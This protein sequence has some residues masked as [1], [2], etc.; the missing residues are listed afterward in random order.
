MFYFI[1]IGKVKSQNMYD[2]SIL[3]CQISKLNLHLKYT[4]IIILLK[5]N[6]PNPNS[7]SSQPTDNILKL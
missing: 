7:S 3:L 2:Y 1:E 4:Q 6:N 5:S